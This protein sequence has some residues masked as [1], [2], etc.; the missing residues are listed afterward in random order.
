MFGWGNLKFWE[1]L[2]SKNFKYF[3]WNSFIFKILCLD[4]IKINCEGEKNEC[5]DKRRYNWCDSP[6]PMDVPWA[7][8]VFL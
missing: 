8:M 7:Q 2:N 1:I 5:K 3:N 6:H 4:K